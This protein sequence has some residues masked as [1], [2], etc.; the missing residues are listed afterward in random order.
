[1]TRLLP[2]LLILLVACGGDTQPAP[3]PTPDA[4]ARS[5]KD[6]PEFPDEPLA[7]EVAPLPKLGSVAL[8]GIKVKNSLGEVVKLT[9]SV[10][11]RS[12]LTYL[13][14]DTRDRQLRAATRM[15]RKLVQSGR[16]MGFR[17]IIVLPQGTEVGDIRV[18]L[19]KRHLGKRPKVFIDHEGAFADATGWKPRTAALIDRKGT[20]GA[21]FGPTTEWDSRVGFDGGLTSDLLALAWALPDDGPEVAPAARQ[22]ALDAVRAVRAGGEPDLSALSQKAPHGAWVTLYRPGTVEQLRG[23]GEGKLGAAVVAAAKAA[24]EGADAA[25]TTEADVRVQIDVPGAP[26]DVPTRYLKSLWYLIEPGVHGVVLGEGD[27]AR[28]MLPGDPVTKGTLSPRVRGRNTKLEAMLGGLAREAKLPKDAWQSTDLKLQRFRT[29]AFGAVTGDGPVVAMYRGNVPLPP[30]DPTEAQILESLRIGGLW[31]ART[32]KD[33]GK[34]DYEYYPN[35]DQGS[36]GYNIVRHAGSVYGLFEMHHLSGEEPALTEGREIYLERAA[37]AM[38]YIYDALGEPKNAKGE[39]RSCLLDRGRCESGSA[40]LTL[41]TFL[42]RPEPKDVPKDLRD[43]IFRDGDEALIEGLGLT[44]LDLIDERGRVFRRYSEAASLDAV[45]KEPLYYPGEAM[46][47][48]LRMYEATGEAKWAD[49][50]RAI[51]QNQMRDYRK[52]RFITP[53]HWVMQGLY[54]LW[55]IDKS[56]DYADV[57]YQM[58]THYCSELY[59]HIFQPFPDYKGSWRR[60]ND[61]PRTTRAGSRSEALRAVMHLAWERGDDAKLYEDTLV[62]ASRHLMEQQ[63]TERNAYWA[64]DLQRVLGAYPMG[65]VDNHVRIDNNQHALVGITGALEAVRRRAGK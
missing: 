39:G 26:G 60:T 24:L 8:K 36:R 11:D 61:T 48:L 14:N 41:L 64:P 47:A 2:L 27:A 57:A 5:D 35:K 54:R 51:A 50:A 31:L 30:E 43:K 53:D 59:P 6:Q 22:A 45:K 63:F 20:V 62:M 3:T 28:T 34:F 21:L 32:V 29:T 42:V 56:D 65:V 33:D 23:F 13:P 58:A 40:A 18:F 37:R 38:G 25:W 15:L 1:V 12:V 19:K 52:D 46:L 44:L 9:D 55:R 49:G 10:A 4:K 16:G 7:L 17:T